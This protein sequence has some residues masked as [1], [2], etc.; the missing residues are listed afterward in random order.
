VKAEIGKLGGGLL[1]MYHS[2]GE[3]DG[4]SIVELPDGVS[5]MASMLA[6]LGTGALKATKTTTLLSIPEAIQG[7]KE[8]SAANLAPPE[9]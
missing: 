2:F 7:M 9:G 6:A 3:F 4:V 1:A 8:A 5:T